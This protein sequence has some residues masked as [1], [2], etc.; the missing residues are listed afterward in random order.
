M[1]TTVTY[2]RLGR[3]HSH[4]GTIVTEAAAIHMEEELGLEPGI[5]RGDPVPVRHSDPP[6]ERYC[7]LTD[8]RDCREPAGPDG[9]RCRFR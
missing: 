9:G 8:C 5:L 6:L 3:P 1:G 4:F 2:Y 7:Q